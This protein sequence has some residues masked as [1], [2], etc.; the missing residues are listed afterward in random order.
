M[1]DCAMERTVLFI[2]DETEG[3]ESIKRILHQH[4]FRV[5]TALNARKNIEMVKQ[6]IPSVIVTSGYTDRPG[7]GKSLS[8]HVFSQNRKTLTCKRIGRGC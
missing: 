6:L 3:L 8:L 1:K 5:E 7:T 2:D 4:A